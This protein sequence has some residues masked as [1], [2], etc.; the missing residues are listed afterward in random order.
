ML[1]LTN[2]N[3]KLLNV[4]PRAELHGEDTK[5]AVDLKFEVKASND[6]LSEF[7]GYLKSALY[8][9]RDSGQQELDMD[10]GHMSQL[11]FPQMGPVKWDHDVAGYRLTFHKVFEQNDIAMEQVEVDGW[12]FDCQDGGTV[13][14]TFRAI[15]HPEA[16]DLGRLC[17]LIQQPVEISLIPPTEDGEHEQ[18]DAA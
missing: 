1:T 13:V 16:K 7:S 11:K 2:Q 6:I 9:K 15:C 18:D 10:P 3:A 5:L 17:E 8:K 12:K 14:T 4:N